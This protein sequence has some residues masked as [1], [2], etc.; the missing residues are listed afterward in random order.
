[1]GEFKLIS[2]N[3]ITAIVTA[4]R[5]SGFSM[6]AYSGPAADDD[7]RHQGSPINPYPLLAGRSPR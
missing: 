2:T 6:I 3:I 5:T 7:K 1:M 4:V